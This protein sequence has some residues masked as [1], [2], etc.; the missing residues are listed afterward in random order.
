MDL[1]LV[2]R[3]LHHNNRLIFSILEKLSSVVPEE[4]PFRH[5]IGSVYPNS[6]EEYRKLF[7]FREYMVPSYPELG[8]TIV[9]LDDDSV[10]KFWLKEF[11]KSIS[12]D[13]I[14]VLIKK[15]NPPSYFNLS[16]GG[17]IPVWD[18]SYKIK[19]TYDWNFVEDF[20]GQANQLGWS[21][22]PHTD[23]VSK[24][25]SLVIPLSNDDEAE[26]FSGTTIYKSK[27]SSCSFHGERA[28]VEDFEVVYTQPHRAGNFIGI[29]KLLDSWHG[30]EPMIT[31][32]GE[33][34]KTIILI[35]RR[36]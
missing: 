33:S 9:Y 3:W 20:G 21:F 23:A 19:Y 1:P 18:S 24:L 13:L 22:P 12:E 31:L 16:G 4:Y 5:I 26:K 10:D 28:N 27:N 29:P 34:R 7:P 6:I 8:R 32:N 35:V 2:W 17:F 11:S 25:M 15:L 14:S 36:K 30:V